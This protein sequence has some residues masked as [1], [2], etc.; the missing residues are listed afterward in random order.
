MKSEIS[1]RELIEILIKGK[2]IIIIA[3]VISS[4]VCEVGSI[5]LIKPSYEAVALLSTTPLTSDTKNRA[6]S[7][8][9]YNDMIDT[10]GRYPDMTVD[11]YKEQF[12]N[13]TVL[14][15][16]INALNIADDN[17][18]PIKQNALA[19]KI[20]VST[21]NTTNLLKVTVTDID[22]ERA[23][24]IA[25]T[26][27]E[28]VIELITNSTRK[29]GEES[30]KKIE[31]LMKKEELKLEE[32]AKKLQE[33]ISNSPNVD[34]MKLEVN[35]LNDK[36]ITYKNN[37]YDVE[38]KILSDQSALNA[39][40][41]SDA[42][43]NSDIGNNVKVNIPINQEDNSASDY[44]FK[45]D[46]DLEINNIELQ[47][48]FNDSKSLDNSIVAIRTTE[49][50]LRLAQNIAKQNSITKAIKDM[51][52]RLN[53]VQSGLTIEEYKYNALKREYDLAEQTYN[54]YLDRYKQ[55]VITAASDMGN[56]AIIVS[57]PAVATT[58]AVGYGRMFYLAVG[59]TLGL[60]VG[61]LIIYFRAYWK[62]SDPKH[63]RE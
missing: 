7:S 58:E 44:K 42:I 52:T 35:S 46:N 21:I 43:S 10:I 48:D 55:A 59:V 17:G 4:I 28:K 50:K 49:M 12:I 40:K 8:A 5:I 29:L 13:P 45:S 23:A 20:K 54:S 3:V 6:T 22:A 27:S 15:E 1:L 18:K 32:Q 53:E 56:T 30:T 24:D 26:L 9:Q 34:Q 14:A 62:S 11:T 16:T 38:E 33:Y 41:V 25:N 60:M 19:K 36:I 51:E 2:W 39:L 37:L 63:V 57:S 31:E 47:L 61:V